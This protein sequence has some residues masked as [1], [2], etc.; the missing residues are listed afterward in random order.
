LGPNGPNKA[1]RDPIRFR[2]LDRRANDSG[3]FRLKY[4]IKA[5]RELPIAIADQK[6][7]PL[8]PLAEPPRELPRLLRDPLRVRMARAASPVHAATGDFDE[9][10]HIQTPQPDDIDGEEV[11]RSHSPLAPAGT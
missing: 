2:N 8:R 4:R 10:Q 1:F 7:N 9:E 5:V 6:P 11:D 3:T